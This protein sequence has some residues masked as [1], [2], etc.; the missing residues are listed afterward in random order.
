MP[1]M[2]RSAE[3]F[4]PTDDELMSIP[5][6]QSISSPVDLPN[7]PIFRYVF[8]SSKEKRKPYLTVLCS[9][10]P[11]WACDD[12]GESFRL[13]SNLSRHRRTVHFTVFQDCPVPDCSRKDIHG[14]QRRDHLVEHLREYHHMDVPKRRAARRETGFGG[15]SSTA[16]P[17][18]GS[19]EHAASVS[20]YGRMFRDAE[21]IPENATSRPSGMPIGSRRS[22]YASHPP[23][24]PPSYFNASRSV[25]SALNSVDSGYGSASFHPPSSFAKY[26]KW[27]TEPSLGPGDSEHGDFHDSGILFP[28]S[29]PKLLGHTVLGDLYIPGPVKHRY[30]CLLA[31]LLAESVACYKPTHYVIDQICEALPDLLEQFALSIGGNNYSVLAVLLRYKR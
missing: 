25:V 22:P 15:A 2:R 13:K 3:P 17:S 6:E 8:S 31:R 14:F 4:N 27:E 5:V 10:G 19:N 18:P 28:V 26:A 11:P 16:S 30:V 21:V 7:E 29:R 24:V 23:T 12:C 20:S 9:P 1:K